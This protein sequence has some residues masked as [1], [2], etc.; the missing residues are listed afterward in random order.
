MEKENLIDKNIE[1]IFIDNIVVDRIEDNELVISF[2]RN[3]HF[4]D[5]FRISI[6]DNHYENNPFEKLE[7]FL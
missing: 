7:K 4:I 5:D 6:F 3:G 2:F 1:P